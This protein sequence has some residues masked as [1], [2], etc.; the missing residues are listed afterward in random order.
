MKVFKI[1]CEALY[2]AI[3][4][5]NQEDAIKYLSELTDDTY[6]LIEEIPESE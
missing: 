4:A 3:Y 6:T 5:K 1:Y 2:Y